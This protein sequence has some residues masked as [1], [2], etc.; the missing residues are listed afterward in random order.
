MH[1]YGLSQPIAGPN[2]SL[3]RNF[4]P[5]TAAKYLVCRRRDEERNT[6]TALP[7]AGDA[8][9]R[10]NSLQPAR[11]NTLTIHGVTTIIRAIAL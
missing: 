7:D 5:G 3:I 1:S 8:G 11:A 6:D 4:V 2:H 10:D 9:C